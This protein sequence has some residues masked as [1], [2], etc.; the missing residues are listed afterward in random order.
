[1]DNGTICD[2]A[3]LGVVESFKAK[4]AVLV[5]AAEA[6]EMLLRVDSIYRSAPRERKGR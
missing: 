4:S 1:L 2:V 5:S 3:A 6:A